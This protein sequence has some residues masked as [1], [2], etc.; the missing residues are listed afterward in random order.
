[1]TT[2]WVAFML[3]FFVSVGATFI[4][5]RLAWSLGVVDEPDGFRKVHQR[6]T[7]RLGGL[8]IYVGFAVPIAALMAFRGLSQVSF[9]VLH[10]TRQL[11]WLFV[12]STLTLALGV[13]DDVY[14]LKAGW[15][16]VWQIL[17]GTV[18]Y[19]CGFSINSIS[20]PFGV[21]FS[22][23]IFSLPVSV[24]WFV[25]C[26]NAVNLLDGLDGLA[27]GMTLFVGLT[28]FLVSLH[29]KSVLG[30]LL[31]ACLSG[32]TLGFL[33]FNFPP[34]RI[35]LGDSGSMLLGFS[36]AA[37]SL[38]GASRKAE[39]GVALFIPVVALGLPI[40]DTFLAIVRRWYKRLPIATPD[41]EHIHH[42]LIA[43][44]YS[45][46]RVVLTLY[47]ICVVLGLAA[48]LITF[49]RNEMVLF[50]IGALVV[51]GF[52]CVRIF[53]GVRFSDVL[54]KLSEDKERRDRAAEAR[55]AVDRAVHQMPNAETLEGLWD[56]CSGVF[57]ALELD[58]AHLALYAADGREMSAKTWHGANHGLAAAE[59]V[60]I[61]GWSC[62]LGLRESDRAHGELVVGQ[63]LERY[64]VLPELPDLLDRVREAMAGQIAR[65]EP[66][67]QSA[68]ESR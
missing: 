32:A 22:L 42:A 36:I 19:F 34:A 38:V 1:M 23:G 64:L 33:V 28:M 39:A 65:L 25:G 53:S 57:E 60:E 2:I 27:A 26:M 10:S 17:I 63:R 46:R 48:L 43:M 54:V 29:F 16:L 20:N 47:V 66:L 40:L 7:P 18:M 31:M 41:R 5:I 13:M 12:G 14:D 61:D 30:M 8:A 44:G 24:F 3:A 56:L 35:F 45:Q 59:D 37:L 6:A 49:G 52:V 4:V 68:D 21:P 50:V 15:K 11:T 55:F 67:K 62:R 58:Y 51:T 9:V